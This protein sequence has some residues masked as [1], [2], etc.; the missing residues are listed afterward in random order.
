MNKKALITL[1][2][3]Y[4]TYSP[5]LF[6]DK[7]TFDGAAGYKFVKHT[8]GT[9]LCFTNRATMPDF[10]IEDGREAT[11]LEWLKQ[12]GIPESGMEA[13]RMQN[14]LKVADKETETLKAVDFIT[15]VNSGS[16]GIKMPNGVFLNV[17]QIKPSIPFLDEIVYYSMVASKHMVIYEY[18]SDFRL[19]VS[20]LIYRP[21]DWTIS[22]IH[23]KAPKKKSTGAGLFF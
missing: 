19:H 12:A 5:S 15:V 11:V 3:L 2:K 21:E 7:D 8:D 23:D 16:K 10:L 13:E 22:E 1:A 6:K 4:S 14:L 20:P 18:D 17:D 9:H